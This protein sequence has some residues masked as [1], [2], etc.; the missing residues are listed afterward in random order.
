MSHWSLRKEGKWAWIGFF[1][2]SWD[3]SAIKYKCWCFSEPQWP[4][5]LSPEKPPVLSQ[6]EESMRRLPN[7]LQPQYFLLR[8]YLVYREAFNTGWFGNRWLLPPNPSTFP[9]SLYSQYADRK[10]GIPI[11][12][13]VEDPVSSLKLSVNSWGPCL[14]LMTFCSVQ[15]VMVRS[16]ALWLRQ[17]CNQTLV[18]SPFLLWCNTGKIAW[19]FPTSISSS[20]KW[21]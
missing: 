11:L 20:I 1:S 15:Y 18:L 6:R 19:P 9:D 3:A 21:R 16:T 12:P 2:R 5:M 4:H 10:T 17:A 7:E 8:L 13:P 14:L